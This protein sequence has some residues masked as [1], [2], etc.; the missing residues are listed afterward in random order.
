M[1]EPYIYLATRR[2]RM[3]ATVGQRASRLG[4]SY[5]IPLYLAPWHFYLKR[6]SGRRRTHTM[7]FAILSSFEGRPDRAIGEAFIR[8]CIDSA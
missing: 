2:P 6:I 1:R 8:L 4:H 3:L 7:I 5:L